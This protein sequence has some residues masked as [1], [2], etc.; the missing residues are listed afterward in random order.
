MT[1]IAKRLYARHIGKLLTNGA[2]SSI[3]GP[4]FLRRNLLTVV[5]SFS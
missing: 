5:L 2:D 1:G 3:D 4:Q